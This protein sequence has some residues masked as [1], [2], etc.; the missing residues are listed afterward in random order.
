MIWCYMD[1]MSV[2]DQITWYNKC[3]QYMIWV[4]EVWDI[5]NQGLG[6]HW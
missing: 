3:V 2:N 6:D 5:G 4:E 1:Q